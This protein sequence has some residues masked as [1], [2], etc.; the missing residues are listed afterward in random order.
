M[1]MNSIWIANTIIG[2][3]T[4]LLYST[5]GSMMRKIRR[6]TRFTKEWITTL[7]EGGRNTR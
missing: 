5:R 2:V 7:R 4:R 6:L 1:M 3:V